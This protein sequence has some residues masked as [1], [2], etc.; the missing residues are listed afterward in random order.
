MILLKLGLLAVLGK[1]FYGAL[2]YAQLIQHTVNSIKK[3]IDKKL[4]V[5]A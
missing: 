3:K 1:K 4:E 5:S 2:I